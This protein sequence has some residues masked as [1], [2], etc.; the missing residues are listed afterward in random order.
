MAIC[1]S[2]EGLSPQRVRQEYQFPQ[3]FELVAPCERAEREI[4]KAAPVMTKFFI[5]AVAIPEVES[6][7]WLANKTEDSKVLIAS[8]KC[9][10]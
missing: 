10:P 1:E 7:V 9:V 3:R 2:I 4:F 5:E 6:S 8:H